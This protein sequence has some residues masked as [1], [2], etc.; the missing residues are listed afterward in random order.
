MATERP[1]GELSERGGAACE[2]LTFDDTMLESEGPLHYFGKPPGRRGIGTGAIPQERS[3]EDGEP[4]V[5]LVIGSYSPSWIEI[6]LVRFL[7]E[8]C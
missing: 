1:S 6:E 5:R 8:I 4:S 3:D 2:P 7:R